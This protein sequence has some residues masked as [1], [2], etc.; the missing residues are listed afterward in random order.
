[1]GRGRPGGGPQAPGQP[2]R[3]TDPKRVDG[4]VLVSVR[5]NRRGTA[6]LYSWDGDT[7]LGSQTVELRPGK[8]Q[9]ILVP[10]SG[11]QANAVLAAFETADGSA[12]AQRHPVGH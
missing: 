11:G 10:V 7:A 12:L 2:L 8:A 5:A 4:G 9:Q 6:Y 3:L 1:M